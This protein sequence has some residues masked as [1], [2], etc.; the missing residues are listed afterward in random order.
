MGILI[1]DDR[2][3]KGGHHLLYKPAMNETRLKQFI[4]EEILTTLIRDFPEE[5]KT[6]LRKIS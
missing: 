5:T 2:T 6:A 3:G 4:A 1:G